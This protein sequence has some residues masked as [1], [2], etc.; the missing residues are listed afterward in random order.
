MA[1]I[2]NP[3]FLLVD[4]FSETTEPNELKVSGSTYGRF[5]IKL[6]QSSMKGE[7][8]LYFM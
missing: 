7:L 6:P 3:F 5:C 4:F 2:G 8:D 1:A